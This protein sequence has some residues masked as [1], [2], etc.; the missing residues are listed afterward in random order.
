MEQLTLS[1]RDS[2]VQILIEQ[3]RKTPAADKMREARLILAGLLLLMF[4]PNLTR[5]S[6]YTT[7]SLTFS[8]APDG[9]AHVTQTLTDIDVRTI[10]INVT[11]YSKTLQNMNLIITDTNGQFLHY[12]PNFY[13]QYTNYSIDTLGAT[14]VYIQ[15]DTYYLTTQ[16]AGIWNF[17]IASAY[18]YTLI[19]PLNVIASASPTP[20]ASYSDPSG[21]KVFT[22]PAGNSEVTY[23]FLATA[24][25]TTFTAP[26]MVG[27]LGIAGG[28]AA[29]YIIF[30]RNRRN[31][32]KADSGKIMRAHP[33]LRPE[34]QGVVNFL[35]QRNGEAMESEI[36]EAFPNIPKTTI[37]RMLK[38]LEEAEVLSLEKV[39]NQNRVQLK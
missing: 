35:A 22:M 13:S 16:S 37:W 14:S 9:N 3:T 2:N 21:Q 19:L 38:R 20:I 4:L 12:S 17:S 31:N 33:E 26:L 24:T 34:E 1:P 39:G 27:I 25:P 7:G 30:H 6:L 23:Y 29:T 5:A 28:S 10:S 11:I 32:R 15:Y 18:N 8:L 36:R